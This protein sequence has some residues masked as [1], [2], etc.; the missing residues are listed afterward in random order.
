[1]IKC[2]LKNHIAKGFITLLV[3]NVSSLTKSEIENVDM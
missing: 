1:M 3:I 2:C